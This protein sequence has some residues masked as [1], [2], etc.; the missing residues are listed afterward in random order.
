M[1]PQASLAKRQ[2]A[3]PCPQKPR[4]A[5]S[6]PQPQLRYRNPPGH[7]FARVEAL[8]DRSLLSLGDLLYTLDDPNVN[9]QQLESGFASQVAVDGNLAVVGVPNAGIGGNANV[10][11]AFVFDSTTGPLLTTLNNSTPGA[12]RLFWR[13]GGRLRE[14][15]GGGPPYEDGTTVNRGAAY[16]FDV[17]RTPTSVDLL[18]ASDTGV[19]S[20]DNLTNLDNSGAAKALQFEVS[21]TIAGA[22]VTVYADGT[23]IG[24]ATAS[25]ITTVVTTSGS[26]NMADGTHAITARQ[27]E[28]GGSES[29]D[30]PALS[31]TVDTVAPTFPLAPDLQLASDTGASHTDNVTSDAT[32]TFDVGAG[33]YFRFYRNGA[34]ISRDYESGTSYTLAAQAD[35]SY[36]Y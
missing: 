1:C 12:T 21:N 35:G 15:G 3:Q 36:R 16:V 10:G 11:R 18:A 30:S 24:S 14:R 32:P 2:C 17:N 20:S 25:G 34:T 23:A 22:T 4:R 19:S 27:T 31:I 5:A 29:A 13:F 8:E 7:R 28:P 33:P 26:R 9:L 6:T